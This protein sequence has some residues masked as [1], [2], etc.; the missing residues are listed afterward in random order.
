MKTAQGTLNLFIGLFSLGLMICIIAFS[1][2]SSYPVY[3][4][5]DS[6]GVDKHNSLEWSGAL[7][8]GLM[9]MA[10]LLSICLLGIEKARIQSRKEPLN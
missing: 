5:Q 9:A 6:T 4:H 10:C 7:A 1:K 3:E 8:F 2:I